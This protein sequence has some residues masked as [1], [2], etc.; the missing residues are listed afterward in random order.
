MW[1]MKTP[2]SDSVPYAEHAADIM[3]A[4]ARPV[5]GGKPFALIASQF[6]EDG[7]AQDV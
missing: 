3:D 2:P 4:A 6:I 7:A 5:P 1:S